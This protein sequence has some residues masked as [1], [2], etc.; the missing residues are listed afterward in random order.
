MRSW[1]VVGGLED[2][3]VGGGL[4]ILVEPWV[5]VVRRVEGSRWTVRAIWSPDIRPPP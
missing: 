5:V 1:R 2:D 3:V 4:K